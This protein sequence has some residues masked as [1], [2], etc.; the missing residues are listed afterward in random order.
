VRE[1]S[2]LFRNLNAATGPVRNLARMRARLALAAVGLLLL[3]VPA[4]NAKSRLHVTFVGDS[5][6]ASLDYV[7]SAKAVMQRG[8][9]LRL[10]LKVCRRLIASSCPYKG[11]APTT[12]LQAVRSYGRSIGDV[13]IVDVGYNEDGRGYQEGIDELMRAA[14]SQGAK[15]VVWVTL[16]ETSDVYHPANLAIRKAARRWPQLVVADW[17]RYSAG[18]PWFRD[19]G[20]HLTPTGADMLAGFLRGYVLRGSRLAD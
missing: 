18:K 13:V 3:A 6:P 4:A 12:A 17:N 7:P 16:R 20:L 15:A 14:L 11:K 1:G 2:G 9:S 10:D 19:D 8:M 5:V